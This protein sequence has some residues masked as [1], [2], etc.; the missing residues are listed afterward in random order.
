MDIFSKLSP[1]EKAELQ[2]GVIEV[3]GNAMNRTAL[4]I[5]DAILK[6]YPDVT[7][8]EL[9]NI[10]PDS[11]NP[12]APKNYKSLFKPYTDRLYGVIQPGSIRQECETQGLNI[13]S[14]HFT[15]EG[16][17]FRL[18]DGTEILVSRTWESKDTETGEHDLQNLIN[19]V[20]QYGVR[21]V[22]FD[23]SKPFTKGGYRLDIINPNLLASLQNPRKKSFV[24]LYILLAALLIVG[25]L[26]YFLLPDN[27]KSENI[28][29]PAVQKDTVQKE[30]NDT[31][32]ISSLKNDI[33][34]GKNTEKRDVSFSDILFEYGKSDLLP[35][36][37]STLNEIVSLMK[38]ISALKLQIIG[39]TS[40][41]GSEGFNNKLSLKRAESVKRYLVSNG[42]EADRLSC[43]GMG[44][45]QPLVENTSEE[46]RI[47]NRR[48][49]F[50]V[51]DDGNSNM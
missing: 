24:W 40:D 31:D 12:S 21:V 44:Y 11:I 20:A 32:A 5:V 51:T 48:T 10:L 22:E 50:V 25:V 41:E 15:D 19:H 18:K 43:E 9:K 7:L 45:K 38:E 29:A 36:S 30:K 27:N 28:P 35:S 37:D 17:T 3:S 6:L 23:K 2:S 47:K 13:N 42:I 34:S 26:V 14:S 8:N 16:E 4:G 1:K 49:Q 33:K 39:H 46:N